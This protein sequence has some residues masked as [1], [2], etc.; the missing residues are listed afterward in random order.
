[1]QSQRITK[2]ERDFE[3]ADHFIQWT[4]N[5]AG[6]VT[7]ETTQM[8]NN[9]GATVNPSGITSSIDYAYDTHGRNTSKQLKVGGV[10]Q[11]TQTQSYDKRNRLVSTSSSA[12]GNGS[13]WS[14]FEYYA[15]DMR[16]TSL[17]EN[18]QNTTVTKRLGLTIL[19]LTP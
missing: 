3:G 7:N 8:P 15:L 13:L 10:T 2:I 1:L 18:Q 17:Q 16:S 9:M 19:Q 11:Y 6:L 4:Y 14:S 12:S 5:Q